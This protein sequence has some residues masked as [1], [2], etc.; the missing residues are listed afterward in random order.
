MRVAR[1]LGTLALLGAS[2]SGLYGCAVAAVAGAGT[3]TYVAS[4]DRA[5]GTVVEDEN[6]EVKAAAAFSNDADIGEQTHINV[7][8]FNNVAL[9][10]GEAPTA[11]LRER[12]ELIVAGIENVRQVY[13][14][15]II[16]APSSLGSRSTDTWITTKAKSAILGSDQLEAWDTTRIKVVTERGVV[17]LMGLVS[18]QEAEAATETI[19][20]V[21]GVQR[22]VRLFEYTD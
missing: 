14:E 15:I 18:R 21:G 5:T 6:I 12:A 20:R 19:R 3:A 1:L 13:N 22:V 2:A 10:T 4:Q 11:D 17:Y 8:S 16:A 7:T 9:M